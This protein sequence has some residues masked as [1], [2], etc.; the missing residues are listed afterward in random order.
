MRKRR[1]I[2]TGVIS[3]QVSSAIRNAIKEHGFGILKA[4]LPPKL[5]QDT[6]WLNT[7]R[8]LKSGYW[9][10]DWPEEH[11]VT[12]YFPHQLEDRKYQTLVT[13]K[14][15]LL[16][17]LSRHDAAIRQTD[18]QDRFTELRKQSAD[19]LKEIHQNGTEYSPE[20]SRRVYYLL[21]NLNTN[22]H[23]EQ[24]FMDDVTQKLIQEGQAHTHTWEHGQFLFIYSETVHARYIPPGIT[25][26]NS[27]LLRS[28]ND[29]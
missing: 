5:H 7:H 16:D 2:A 14:T 25:S 6:I 11:I 4:G 18:V 22:A 3:G 19:L 26:D 8:H 20:N 23:A 21:R 17:E 28:I 10:I 1:E 27:T 12:L 29:E 24:T 9:H 13:G 15:K